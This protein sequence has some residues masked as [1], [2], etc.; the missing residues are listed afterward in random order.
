[1]ACCLTLRLDSACSDVEEILHYE[2]KKVERLE[3]KDETCKVEE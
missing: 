3:E 2:R 1:M